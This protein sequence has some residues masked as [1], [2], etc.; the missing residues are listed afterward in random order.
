MNPR[1]A[2]GGAWPDT[3]NDAGKA[4]PKFTMRAAA[5]A[6]A[7]TQRRANAGML[8]TEEEFK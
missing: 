4:L 5:G 8:M 1:E 3:T 6:K 7:I 2:A